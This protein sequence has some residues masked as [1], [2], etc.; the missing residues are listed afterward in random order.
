MGLYTTGLRNMRSLSPGGLLPLPI[1]V[2]H[3]D[4]ATIDRV[5]SALS[6]VESDQLGEERFR[7]PAL[8]LAE[9]GLVLGVIRVRFDHRTDHLAGEP[10]KQANI[11]GKLGLKL[12]M[13]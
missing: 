9:D 11:R 1:L 6:P 3:R 4:P 10:L 5:C 12:S 7:L 2:S 13:R 8:D